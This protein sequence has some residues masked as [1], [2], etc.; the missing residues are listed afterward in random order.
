MSDNTAQRVRFG[1]IGCADIAW[2]RTLPAM[3]ANPAIDVVAVGSRDLARA[4]TFTDRYGG[5]P[6]GS[7]QAVAEHPGVDAVYIPLPLMMHA[8]WVEKCLEAGKH[9]LV[10]KPMTDG[11]KESHRLMDL[12]RS[13]GLLLLE[14][15]MFLHH[16]QHAE[17]RKMIAEG[18]IGE[19]RGFNGFFT[20]PPKPD[21]DIR[22]QPDVGGG[23]FLDFGGYPIRAALH[24]LGKELSVVGAVFRETADTGVVMSGS[25]LLTSP[26]GIPAQLSFGMEHS[27]QNSYSVFGSTGRLLVDWAFTPPETHRPVVRIDRQDHRE[28]ITLAAHHQFASII[29]S[30]VNAVLSGE[31]LRAEQEGTLEQAAL[32]EQVSQQAVRI[33]I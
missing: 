1:V 24:V 27:Y 7:Y 8:E 17:V 32:M 20:I 16:T 12:A 26:E 18:D 15:Y 21:G 13:R 5:E 28:E 10:E 14:N 22:Y 31:E 19:V 9:V 25:V 30:F 11:Y 6:L 3:V 2:R 23:A 33:K 29:G 4:R